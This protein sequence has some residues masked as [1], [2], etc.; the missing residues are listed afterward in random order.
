M[1]VYA[2]AC[3]LTVGLSNHIP[4]SKSGLKTCDQRR[5]TLIYRIEPSCG[6]RCVYKGTVVPCRREWGCHL[7]EHHNSILCLSGV[8]DNYNAVVGY[9][10]PRSVPQLTYS[11]CGYTLDPTNDDSVST[12]CTCN[13]LSKA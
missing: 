2:V 12:I 1:V 11:T 8:G 13:G 7:H 10:H 9:F 4:D 3:I 5:H 6:Y